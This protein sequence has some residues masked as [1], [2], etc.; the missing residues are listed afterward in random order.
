MSPA[1]IAFLSNI[2]V[3]TLWSLVLIA[4]GV[5]VTYQVKPGKAV[6]ITVLYWVIGLI[7]LVGFAALG[8]A[9]QGALSPGSG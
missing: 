1:L 5:A 8:A 2:D 3:F 9:F 7:L 6:A 4:V